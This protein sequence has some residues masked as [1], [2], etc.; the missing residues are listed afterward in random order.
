MFYVYVVESE[1]TSSFYIGFTSRLDER[2]KEHNRGQSKSTKNRGP[3]KLIGYLMTETR[4]EAM[5][6]ERKLKS[7]KR[8]DRVYNY[9]RKHGHLL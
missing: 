1:T 2:I 6:L 3:W 8:K 4:S 7:F 9:I 5:R